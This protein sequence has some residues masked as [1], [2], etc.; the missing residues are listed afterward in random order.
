MRSKLSFLMIVAAA[1][2]ASAAASADTVPVRG[3]VGNQEFTGFAYHFGEND[4]TAW[5]N[6]NVRENMGVVCTPGPVV[7][8]P[9]PPVFVPGP[10]HFPRPFPGPVVVHP[11]IHYPPVCAPRIV[12]TT[13]P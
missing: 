13:I 5:L 6:L 1:F 3:L 4:G 10:G 2:A 12:D 9:R 7:V 11:P 8:G